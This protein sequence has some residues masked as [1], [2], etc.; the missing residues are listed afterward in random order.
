MSFH[1]MDRALVANRLRKLMEPA[2][3]LV[4]LSPSSFWRGQEPW[5]Q[6]IIRTI[7]DWLGGERRAGTGVFKPAPLHQECLAQT[8]FADIKVTEFHKTHVCPPTALS[9]IC[10]RPPSHHARYLR[11]LRESFE[12]DL[13]ERL[14]RLSAADQFAEEN[15]F[16][17]VSARAIA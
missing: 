8:P 13:R 6:V 5:Q 7:K 3:G 17:T 4:A 2:G 9:A 16:S 14:S 10:T 1:W 12:D 15:E 11:N